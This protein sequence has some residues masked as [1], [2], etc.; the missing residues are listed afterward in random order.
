MATTPDDAR[1]ALARLA[2]ELRAAP[3]GRRVP[4]VKRM[5]PLLAKGRAPLPVRFA[6]AAHAV[7][8][9]PNHTGVA[10]AVAR[11]LT[12]RL[13]PAKQ[14]TRLR[15]LQNLTAGAPALD[16]LVARRE[17]KVRMS[18]PRCA[19]KLP[20]TEMAGHLWHEHRLELAGGTVRSVAQ[21]VEAL[22]LRHAATADPELIDRAAARAGEAA[23]RAWAA[24]TA[25]PD[26]AAP[27]CTA[28][29]R[30]WRQPVPQLLER[31]ATA[32]A[33]AT[34][35]AGG[36]RRARGRGRA[37]R[38]GTAAVP[39]AGA[40]DAPGRG[41]AARVRRGRRPGEGGRDATRNGGRRADRRCVPDRPV[42]VSHPQHARRSGDRRGVEDAGA[43]TPRPARGLRGSW[44]GCA[45]PASAGATRSSGPTP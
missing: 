38:D 32:G 28:C 18:C 20:R 9:L 16:A 17:R 36:R 15:H 39:A 7:D 27:L 19:V 26:E 13:S 6:A 41:R 11:A 12:A 30:A 10:R 22:R 42:L 14:L 25:T 3:P 45:S 44:C 37:G 21:S 43:A 5:L 24:E 4:V 1:A 23:V 31:R 35:P 34:A 33:R 8:A 40:G 29:P 2:A